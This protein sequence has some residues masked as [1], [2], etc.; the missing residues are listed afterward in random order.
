MQYLLTFADDNFIPRI[1]ENLELLIN[2][3]TKL[4]ESTTKWLRDS[5]LVVNKKQIRDLHTLQE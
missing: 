4:L 1:N 5:G 3:F 2:D